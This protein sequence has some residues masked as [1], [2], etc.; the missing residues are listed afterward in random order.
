MSST[1]VEIHKHKN[2]TKP[3]G[4]PVESAPISIKFNDI[5]NYRAY[6]W[7]IE[8]DFPSLYTTHTYITNY[9]VCCVLLTD[10]LIRNLQQQQLSK[11]N[12]ESK[13]KDQ[14]TLDARLY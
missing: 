4:L 7:K 12:E 14:R 3:Y 8:S 13:Q 10:E 1:H 11:G 2:T 6:W 9:F 5:I